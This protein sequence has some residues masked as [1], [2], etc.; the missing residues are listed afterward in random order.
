MGSLSK[1]QKFNMEKTQISRLDNLASICL[2]LFSFVSRLK[3]HHVLLV[4]SGKKDTRELFFDNGPEMA[5]SLH[6]SCFP[7]ILQFDLDGHS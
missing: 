3:G 6:N 5:W 7:C 2:P 4:S 1:Y